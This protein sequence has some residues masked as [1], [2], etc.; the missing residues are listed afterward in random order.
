[1]N[2]AADRAFP[3]PEPTELSRPFWDALHD[4]ALTFQRCAPCGRGWLPARAHCPHC[5]SSDWRRERASG[6]ARLV[7]WVVYR[8][9]YH[10]AFEHRL[11]YTV[12]VVE[13]AE[14]PRMISNVVGPADGLHIDQPLRL[15]VQD[16][17]GVAV[18]RFEP[19]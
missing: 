7:S 3:Q 12:A 6:D 19:A 14:G 5:L 10:P 9:A 15:V 2:D 4:G 13:L 18:P 1:M 8:V 17:S 16:E 11:P